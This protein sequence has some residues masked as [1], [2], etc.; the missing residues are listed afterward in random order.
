MRGTT[1]TLPSAEAAACQA[2][3]RRLRDSYSRAG[4]D[5]LL[6]SNPKDIRYLTGFIGHDS[7]LLVSG[8][9]ASI[10]TDPRYDEALEPWRGSGVAQVVLGKQHRLEE[11]IGERCGAKSIR[12][13]GVQSEHVTVAMRSKFV[14]AISAAQL[15]DTS[16]LVGA[17]RQV[18]DAV[19]LAA[20]E[21][22]IDV[23]QQAMRAALSRLR[24]G[25]T[26]LE[27]C[28]TLE[29]EIKRR[30]AEGTSFNTMVASGARS[31]II[32]YATSLSPIEP[33]VLLVDWGALVG[34]YCSDMTRTFALERVPAKVAEIYGVVLE[35]QLAA[36]DACAPG[37]TC[38][39]V[40][41]VARGIITRAGYGDHFGHGLGHGLGLDIHEDPYFNPLMTS[42]VLQPGMVMTVEPGI[43][44]PGVGG[45]RIEDDVLITDR[46]ARVLTNFP[47]C[48]D[49]ALLPVA[50]GRAALQE[51]LT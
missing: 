31:S 16:G 5:A 4:I 51:A 41:A 17:L 28:A 11:T 48:L 44:L 43:Y 39:E 38:A 42:A 36:I 14:G 50:P 13:L 23:H 46:G 33:G 18:K 32:H 12:R 40:D 30:G 29:Y 19:E 8:G 45:V 15:I 47:K 49:D 26:E 34:G 20:I 9:D 24:A 35:A 2:R 27:F 25:M 21:H 3:Q 37:R 1:T 7:L 22:A 6:V 10:V